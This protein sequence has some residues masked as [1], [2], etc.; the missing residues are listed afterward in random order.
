MKGENPLESM[1]IREMNGKG[2]EEK[3]RKFRAISNPDKIVMRSN[4]LIF[5]FSLSASLR[6]YAL[7]L[8]LSIS[9]FPIHFPASASKN[10]FPNNNCN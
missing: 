6:L 4:K 3:L 7:S 10:V 2:R 8:P 5:R 1:P 9:F